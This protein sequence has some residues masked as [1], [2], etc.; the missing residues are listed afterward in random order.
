MEDTFSHK[1]IASLH[2]PSCMNALMVVKYTAGTNLLL[3]GITGCCGILCTRDVSWMV[4]SA[5]LHESAITIHRCYHRV[6]LSHE[7]TNAVLLH[8]SFKPFL[9]KN[10]KYVYIQTCN[11]LDS[12]F[13]TVGKQDRQCCYVD[14]FVQQLPTRLTAKCLNRLTFA[15]DGSDSGGLPVEL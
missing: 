15:C 9:A 14:G 13:K 10:S 11:Q 8:T 2:V 7:P 5:N 12:T 6:T 3:S 1:S 4:D